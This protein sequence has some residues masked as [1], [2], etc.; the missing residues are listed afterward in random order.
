MMCHDN[1][2][3]SSRRC[4]LLH[5]PTQCLRVESSRVRWTE[6]PVRRRHTN[7]AKIGH[8]CLRGHFSENRIAIEPKISP[9]SCSEEHDIADLDA[10]IFQNMD[11]CAFSNFF[12]FVDE[13]RNFLS[14][15]L[16]VSQHIDCRSVGKTLKNP[17]NSVLSGVNVAGEHNHVG[18]HIVRLERRELYME[19]AENMDTHDRN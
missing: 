5:Q 8:P 12:D 11:V 16:V 13:L 15:E 3:L 17:F 10:F 1:G 4:G 6:A 19:I 18:V 7:P 14:V 2:R 9:K